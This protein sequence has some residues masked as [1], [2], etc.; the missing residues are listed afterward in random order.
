MTYEDF[1]SSRYVRLRRIQELLDAGQL[2]P[3]LRRVPQP[4]I[5]L[6]DVR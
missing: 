3:M 4:S 1:T 2:D 6:T 5:A